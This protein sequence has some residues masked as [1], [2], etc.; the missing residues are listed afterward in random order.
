MD[1]NEEVA[2]HIDQMETW[3]AWRILTKPIPITKE[4]KLKV[5]LLDIEISEVLARDY[6]RSGLRPP[7]NLLEAS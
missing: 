2:A 3:E 1:I 4:Q 7:S 5:L 6:V